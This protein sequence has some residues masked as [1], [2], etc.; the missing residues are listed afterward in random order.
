MSASKLHDAVYCLHICVRTRQRVI[1]S[2]STVFFTIN[3]LIDLSH[4]PAIFNFLNTVCRHERPFSIYISVLREMEWEG[5][6][7]C[8]T[9]KRNYFSH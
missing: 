5:Y 7:D 8:G 2:L 3:G 1:A 6:M 4:G 9:S